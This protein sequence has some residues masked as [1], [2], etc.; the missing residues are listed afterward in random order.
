LIVYFY[1]ITNTVLYFC[2]EKFHISEIASCLARNMGHQLLFLACQSIKPSKHY[3]N[4]R[5]HYINQSRLCSCNEHLPDLRGLKQHVY[6]DSEEV[7]APVVIQGSR[8]FREGLFSISAH[9]HAREQ[10]VPCSEVPHL[11]SV[12]NSQTKHYHTSYLWF[13][14]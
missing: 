11:I 12:H 10:W 4:P 1:T 13:G 3:I 14:A 5:R 2:F 8:L 9:L 6:H 7:S